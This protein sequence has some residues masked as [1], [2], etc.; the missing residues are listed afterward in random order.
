[1]KIALF[2]GSFN[3]IHVGHLWMANAAIQYA[4]ADKVLFMPTGDAPHKTGV[5][6]AKYRYKMVEKAIDG[7]ANFTIS[8]YEIQKEGKSYTIETVKHL[9][10]DNEIA[11]LIGEDSFL[12]MHSWY[13]YEE[14]IK[15]VPL[16]VVPRYTEISLSVQE[17][18]ERLKEKGAKVHFLPMDRIE[19][20]ST[21]I[22]R[23]VK[24]HQSIF[25][26]VPQKVEKYIEKHRLYREEKT[27]E[28]L[29]KLEKTLRPKTYFHSIRVALW[30][31][32]LAEIHGYD[33][34]NAGLA[35][36]LH[37]NAKG[38]ETKVLEDDWIAQRF[39]MKNDPAPIWHQE[40]GMLRAK[41]VYGI[42]NEEILH[43]INNH[44]TGAEDM[45][46]LDKLLFIADK[47]EPGREDPNN[48][49]IRNKAKENVDEAFFMTLE[50]SIDYIH[51]THGLIHPITEKIYKQ[52][53]ERRID[54]NERTNPESH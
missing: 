12:Q 16:W 30:M 2:G 15:L 35:G 38:M 13:K 17:Q 42:S 4:K 39:T 52:E 47:T 29:A 5:L 44:T 10:K 46:P 11:L 6:E 7:Q 23:K 37:D 9:L 31:E 54:E 25:A 49:P 18:Y 32:E 26:A 53:K 21:D 14:L 43:S 34:E 50:A 24:Y 1:M 48:I 36:L 27:D 19:I 33:V 3:P 51:K 28:I 20:S 22:R 40:L 45:G 41:R 8:D